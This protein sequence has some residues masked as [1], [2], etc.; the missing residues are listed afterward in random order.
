MWGHCSFLLCPGIHKFLFVPSKSLFP[1]SRVSS[2]GS[3][4]ELMATSSKRVLPYPGLLHPEPLSFQ[5]ST[6]DLYLLRR[7]SN[8]VLSQSL[9]GLLV[10]VCTRF[11][12]SECLWQIWGLILNMVL[13]L[14][15]SC[16][17]FS[18]ALGHGVS[19]QVT[20]ARAAT[21][22]ALERRLRGSIQFS[23]SV[24]SDSL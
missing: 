24:M 6:S 10:L 14:L 2:G 16:W 9:W 11:E 17:G 3:V 5:Q 12:P 13:T 21:A 19:P 7:H 8:T 15:P 1:Q 4:V 22:P 23:G 18:F 20:P